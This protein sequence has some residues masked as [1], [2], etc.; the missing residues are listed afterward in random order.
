MAGAADPGTSGSGESGFALFQLL[1]PIRNKYHGICRQNV[2]DDFAAR[3][4]SLNDLTLSSSSN[5]PILRS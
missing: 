3:S 1:V 2:P 5:I 4:S